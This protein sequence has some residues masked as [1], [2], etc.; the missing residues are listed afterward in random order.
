MRRRLSLQPHHPL[1]TLERRYRAANDPIARSHRQVIWL[2]AWGLASAQIAAVSGY[3]INWV[4]PIAQ[5]YNQ[6]GPVGLE[7]RRH[8]N[9]GRMGLFL[10]SQ[11]ATLAPR[12]SRSHSTGS[13]PKN[14]PT[15]V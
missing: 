4:R 2:L 6:H 9:P 12:E 1:E 5:R 14:L 10:A 8:W 11:R 3:T 15:V 7:E 13:L